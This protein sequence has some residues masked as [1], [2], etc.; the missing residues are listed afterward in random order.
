MKD[1]ATPILP[2]AERIL[3]ESNIHPLMWGLWR[4]RIFE[5]LKRIAEMVDE[6]VDREVVAIESKGSMTYEG[7]TV[8]GRADRIDRL[9]DGT[10]AIVDYKTGKP[11]SKT[12][13]EKG[14]AL[15][16]GTLGLIA[17]EGD[18]GGL[19][20]EAS[21]FEY[22]S[23][24]KNKDGGFGFKEQ[25]MKLTSQQGGI[26][27]EDFLPEHERYLREAITKFIK[28]DHPF[29]ARLN[30]DYPGYNDYDQLMRLEE[31]QIRL[32]DNDSEGQP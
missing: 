21:L 27:P 31:W 1:P 23:L 3:R 13:V 25:P 14:F 6:Q 9:A 29:T 11:P 17:R 16:L 22:W 7:V 19:S 8:Y 26:L 10:L 24:A 18:F 30:P 15:Q 28:G 12:K 32:A 4:P 5:G 20:G 2:L